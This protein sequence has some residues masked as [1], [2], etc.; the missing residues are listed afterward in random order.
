[1]RNI[2]IIIQFDGTA[3]HGWQRQENATTVQE[4]VENGLAEI[5]GE[6]VRVDGCGRTDAGVH[7]KGYCC[8]FKTNGSIPTEKIPEALNAHLPA[9]IVCVDACDVADDFDVKKSVRK[10]YTYLINNGNYPDVFGR[11]YAWYY[12]YPLDVEKMQKAAKAFIGEHDFVG[13]AASGFT[14]KTTVRTIYSL[15]IIPEN[16]IIR[17]EICGNGFLYNMVRIIVGTLVF[18][19]MGKMACDE[20][21]AIIKS[22]DRTRAGITAPACGL[23]L[24]EVNY[25]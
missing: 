10:R 2:K 22:C 14:V 25:R 20:I 13:F 17:I 6:R 8:G 12:K 23:Y 1:M 24:S 3:Y 21:P 16:D 19:G 7:A 15:D 5:L 9:D 4:T 11:N 18:C